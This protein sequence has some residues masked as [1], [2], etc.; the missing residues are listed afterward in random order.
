MK[1]LNSSQLRV[2][3]HIK[4]LQLVFSPNKLKNGKE[5]DEGPKKMKAMHTGVVKGKGDVDSDTGTNNDDDNVEK[6]DGQE[7]IS[8]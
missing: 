2:K 8:L 3:E 7:E 5:D 6:K 1:P 4:K